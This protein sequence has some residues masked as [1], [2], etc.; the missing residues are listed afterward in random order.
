MGIQ[1]PG[2]QRKEAV[3]K[4]EAR[5]L[6]RKVAAAKKELQRQQQ[7]RRSARQQKSELNHL[8]VKESFAIPN[9]LRT[10]KYLRLR[11]C[12]RRSARG[13]SM[14]SLQL[15]HCTSPRRRRKAYTS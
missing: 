6:L 11:L 9:L 1:Q 4:A 8:L 3:P 15:R 2:W 12:R 5:R 7:I 13:Q 14:I 10:V